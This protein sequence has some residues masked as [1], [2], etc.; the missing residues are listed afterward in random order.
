MTILYSFLYVAIGLVLSFVLYFFYFQVWLHSKLRRR[1]GRHKNVFF[2]RDNNVMLGDAPRLL[3]GIQ[4]K[5]GNAIVNF[6]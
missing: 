2:F 3:E 4:K 6:V 5:K 1:F